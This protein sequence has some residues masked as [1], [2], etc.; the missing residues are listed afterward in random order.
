MQ[1]EPKEPKEP[2][3]YIPMTKE[4]WDSLGIVR[5]LVEIKDA[6]GSDTNTVGIVAA[7]ASYICRFDKL[8]DTIG[9]WPRYYFTEKEETEI[10]N[11]AGGKLLQYL[12]ESEL[13]LR[14]LLGSEP[15][16]ALEMPN[17]ELDQNS[18]QGE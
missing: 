8:I 12:Q 10:L 2:Q 15:W 14:T 9:D 3:E 4:H 6:I 18:T 11:K 13:K 1:E 17:P 7:I 5:K 16:K